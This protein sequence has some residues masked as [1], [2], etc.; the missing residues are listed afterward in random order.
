VCHSSDHRD[1]SLRFWPRVC[2]RFGFTNGCRA[3][4]FMHHAIACAAGGPQSPDRLKTLEAQTAPCLRR[5]AHRCM[6]DIVGSPQ[7]RA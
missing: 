2:F 7:Q 1:T 4:P 6:S 5:A 3:T